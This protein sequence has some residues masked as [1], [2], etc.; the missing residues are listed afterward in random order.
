VNRL[1]RL[2]PA[3]LVALP[4]GC[5]GSR[6]TNEDFV[7][8]EAA[9]RAALEAYLKAWAAGN[10]DTTVPG[11]RPAVMVADELRS[12]GRTLS[13]FAVLGPVP[14]DAPRCFAVK[15]TLGNPR[16]EVRERYVVVGIDPV[17]VWRYDDYLMITHWE[18]PMSAD[19]A[20]APPRPARR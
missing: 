2:V 1:S 16:A 10:T 14:A 20:P 3:V 15:L 4:L 8:P 7:P 9:A 13:A 5:S 12:K 11:T 18:H 19:A 17:W 6:Q